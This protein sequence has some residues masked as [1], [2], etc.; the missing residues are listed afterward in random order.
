MAPKDQCPMLLVMDAGVLQLG[1]VGDMSLDVPTCSPMSRVKN[2]LQGRG[3]K[4]FIEEEE[5]NKTLSM[6]EEMY[7]GGWSCAH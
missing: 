4:K 5:L 1:A 6:A 3:R 2:G 7:L